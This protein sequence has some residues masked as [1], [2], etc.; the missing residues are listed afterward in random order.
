MD[1]IAL[2]QAGFPAAV[3]PLGTAL[4]EEQLRELWRLAPEPVLC[5]DGDAAG[6]R[7]AARAADRALPLL[8]PGC[9]LR[10]VTLPVGEDPDSLLRA[11]GPAAMRALIQAARPL[12]DVL[13]QGLREAHRLDTPE[14]QAALR[15]AVMTTVER[16]GDPSVQAAYRSALLDRYFGQLR[17]QREVRP[18]G[19]APAAGRRSRR[20]SA[21]AG[22]VLA[23]PTVGGLRRRPV[24]ILLALSVTHPHLAVANLEELARPDLEHP[25]LEALRR[26]LVDAL[27]AAPDL[28]SDRLE[29]HL[30]DQGFS[31]LLNRLL[32]PTISI[33]EPAI[34]IDAVPRE[35][36]ERFAYWLER[37]GASG[38]QTR[39]RGATS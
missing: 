32:G 38:E 11:S 26:A 19:R 3:A 27:A 10:F 14:R 33:H 37:V 6:Q 20:L 16:V 21:E 18:A 2:A 15:H 17:A 29:C 24:E 31:G 8:R 13:W 23:R 30:R 34:R 4:T 25:E 35:A 22:P 7:A 28:D 1:V 36:G 9:S 39:K 5:L 12:V